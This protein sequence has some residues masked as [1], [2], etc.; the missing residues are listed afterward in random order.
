MRVLREKDS[1]VCRVAEVFTIDIE[2]L[3]DRDI[4]NQKPLEKRQIDNDTMQK[5][6]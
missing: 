4:F 6:R 3:Y 5:K 2:I 1:N